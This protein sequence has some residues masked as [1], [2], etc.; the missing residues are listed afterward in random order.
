[1]HQLQELVE[2][3]SKPEPEVIKEGWHI[4]R[5]VPN[6][7]LCASIALNVRD[8]ET[9]CPAEYKP[10][11]TNRMENGRRVTESRARA[12]ITGYGF[13]RFDPGH[14]DFEGVRRI[15][16]VI[17]F[18]K[19]EGKP[20]GLRHS[21]VER[22]RALDAA[23]FARHQREMARKAAEEADRASGKPEVAFEQGKEVQID[24]P[25]GERWIGRMM[26]QRGAG[27]VVIL[28]ENA[29]IIVPHTRIH[30]IVPG[31]L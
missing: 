31:N 10:Q 21:E 9:F 12:M 26:Q 2:T 3:E 23:E 13:I 17:D 14:W 19:I 24:G 16:G 11:R 7:E 1:M 27:R 18:M 25:L 8:Y 4:L 28:R 30:E 6:M 20:A 15:K 29:K 5:F 22:F